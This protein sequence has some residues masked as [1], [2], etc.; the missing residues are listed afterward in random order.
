MA[1][2]SLQVQHPNHYTDI[3]HDVITRTAD[4]ACE[5]SSGVYEMKTQHFQS[6]AQQT[7]TRTSDSMMLGLLGTF[8]A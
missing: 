7:Q 3:A 6:A 2:S 1:T 4:V 8:G 5:H